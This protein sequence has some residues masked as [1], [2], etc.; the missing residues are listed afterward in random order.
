MAVNQGK[1]TEERKAEMLEKIEKI[2]SNDATVFAGTESDIR[3]TKDSDSGEL[4]ID[5]VAHFM[6]TN[7]DKPDEMHVSYASAVSKIKHASSQQQEKACQLVN[8]IIQTSLK[9]M[10]MVGGDKERAE[11]EESL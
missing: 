7:E 6:K 3:V 9:G 1:M 11:L 10:N 2:A 8:R 5:M 4:V